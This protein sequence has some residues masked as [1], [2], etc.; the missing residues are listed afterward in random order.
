VRVK[1][2]NLNKFKELKALR[3]F[4]V[5]FLGIKGRI[6]YIMKKNCKVIT[7]V[8]GENI[9]SGFAC[10]NP[11]QKL[12]IIPMGLPLHC[13]YDN[14]AHELVHMWQYQNG[15]YMHDEEDTDHKAYDLVQC[16]LIDKVRKECAKLLRRR[17]K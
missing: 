16:Y 10:C 2:K 8:D 12:V 7:I 15:L 3:K 5:K 14:L 11:S 9:Y 4:I 6:K 1:N 17:I 13:L